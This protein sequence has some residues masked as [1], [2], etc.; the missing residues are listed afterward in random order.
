VYNLDV[1]DFDTYFVGEY[2]VLVHNVCKLGENM[3]KSGN[4][5][6]NDGK[7]IMRIT[8]FHKNLE[9][10]FETI[11]IDVDDPNYGIWVESH[12]HL[13]NAFSYNQLWEKEIKKLKALSGK[14]F[15]DEFFRFMREL[16]RAW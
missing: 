5:A 14:A 6:P 8:Y 4:Y 7:I 12:E 15:D 3:R 10:F 1:A 9:I 2:G 11:G 13:K 16:S